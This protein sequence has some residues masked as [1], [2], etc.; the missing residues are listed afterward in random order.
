[1][2]MRWSRQMP[3]PATDWPQLAAL[4]QRMK[5]RPSFRALYAAE[6]LADWT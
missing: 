3:R 2:L 5:A 6:G 1:M 4:A